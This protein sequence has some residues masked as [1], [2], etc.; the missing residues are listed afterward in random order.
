MNSRYEYR[1]RLY[2]PLLSHHLT[3]NECST[4]DA[5]SCVEHRAVTAK[6]VEGVVRACWY[7][8]AHEPD[9]VPSRCPSVRSDSAGR[10]EKESRTTPAGSPGAVPGEGVREVGRSLRG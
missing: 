4:R 7:I 10:R 6:I 9:Y 2:H 8:A 5:K 3:S 1:D